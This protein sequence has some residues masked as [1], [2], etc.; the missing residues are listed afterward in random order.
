ME[1]A[2]EFFEELLKQERLDFGFFVKLLFILEALHLL[3]AKSHRLLD[4]SLHNNIC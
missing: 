2:H 4:E 3:V 1:L